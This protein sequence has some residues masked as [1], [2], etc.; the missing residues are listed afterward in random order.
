MKFSRFCLLS[1]LGLVIFAPP[2]AAKID[3][4]PRKVVVEGRERSGDITV[5]NLGTEPSTFRISLVNYS[6]NNQGAYTTLSGPLN[7]AFD[8]EKVVR[9]SPRQFTLPVGGRQKI[10]FT[11]RTPPDLPAGEYRFH[12]QTVE[13]AQ[14]PL[15]NGEELPKETK[16]NM[17][18]NLGVTIPVVFRNGDVAATGKITNVGFVGAAQAK[19]GKP[20]LQMRIER[21]GTASLIG[22]LKAMWEAP[23]AEPVVVASIGNMNIFTD[24]EYRDVQLPL[25]TGVPAG[26]GTLRLVYTDATPNAKG[27]VIDEVIVQR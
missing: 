24:V 15:N 2:A 22:A 4:L 23:G 19:E 8:P 13:L 26:Q 7:P 6:Q 10:R 9:L 1:L 5:L 21:K 14:K 11:L 20:A 12:I 3:M 16:I 18:M 17:Q 25:E 27:K